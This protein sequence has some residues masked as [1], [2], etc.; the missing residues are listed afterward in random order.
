MSHKA[1]TEGFEYEI[2]SDDDNALEADR[3]IQG[4]GL[5]PYPMQ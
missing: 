2:S 3:Y 5:T 1:G 4:M